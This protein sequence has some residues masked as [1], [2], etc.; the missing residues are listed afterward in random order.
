MRGGGAR[1][2]G[3]ARAGEARVASLREEAREGHA[4][5]PNSR[6]TREQ[7]SPPPTPPLH[8]AQKTMLRLATSL[9]LLSSIRPASS[10]RLA[11]STGLPQPP[12][13]ALPRR[14]SFQQHRAFSASS[15]PTPM[16]LNYPRPTILEPKAG[17]K[18]SAAVFIMHGLGD[19]AVSGGE[20]G[21]RRERGPHLFSGRRGAA[22]REGALAR[23][24]RF[25]RPP[26][27]PFFSL[28]RPAGRTSPTSSGPPS[29]T[30][31][32]SCPPPP[33]AP[34]PS[35]AATPCPAGTTSTPWTRC[36]GGRT[37]RACS[38]RPPTSTP[39]WKRWRPPTAS[40]RTGW[41]WRASRRGGPWRWPC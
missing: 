25:D 24:I 12:S 17:G 31:A 2:C 29:P 23:T 41:S 36:R 7:F 19:T 8:S 1:A 28:N 35:T 22:E 39:C 9:A 3:Q 21:G 27:A 15:E 26:P 13:P 33:P 14:H 11:P 6:V 5:G 34:S 20:K 10:P 30:P 40:R 18:P 37:G 4:P 38:P 32:S 16:A